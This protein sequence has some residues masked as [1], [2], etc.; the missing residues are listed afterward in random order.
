M[1]ATI[2]V[3]LMDGVGLP[4]SSEELGVFGNQ[5]PPELPFLN[6]ARFLGRLTDA[7]PQ[8]YGSYE[9][10]GGL[11]LE[12]VGDVS[13]WEAFNASKA[14]GQDLFWNALALLKDVQER[15]VDDGTGCFAFRQA[16]D[17]RL[18]GWEFEHFLEYGLKPV[19]DMDRSRCHGELMAVAE[20]LGKLPRAFCHRDYH[21]WNIHVQNERLRL[22][23]FQDAL[24]APRLYDVASLLTDRATPEAVDERR[25]E[26]LVRRFAEGLPVGGD[27][28]EVYN[29]L[30]F[31]RVL[32]VIG[33]FNFLAERKAKPRY[34]QM[35]PGVVETARRLAARIVGIDCTRSLLERAVKAGPASAR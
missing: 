23:D 27:P 26:D 28:I 9:A 35:L 32:K 18:F 2:V 30:A 10:E 4:M 22:L 21:A 17:A 8:V 5:G 25:A 11:V 29:L 7:V 33:R 16:F 12:D 20:R 6:I 3:M 19:R 31:Q 1:P 13:L 34:L 14:P 15:A 24:L